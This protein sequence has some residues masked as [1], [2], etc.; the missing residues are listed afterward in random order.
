MS[1]HFAERFGINTFDK[2]RMKQKLP[3]PVYQKWKNATRKEDVLDRDTADMIA[4]AMKTWAIENGATHYCHWFQPLNGL[5]AKKHDAFLDQTEDHE[6]IAR[7]SGKE[8]IKGE[9]DASSFPSGGMRST[10][11]A[12]GYTYWDCTANTFIVD[13][14][15]YIPSIFVSFNGETLD[16]KGPL[17]KSM[18]YLS[19]H[20]NRVYNL[21]SDVHSYRCRVKVGLEQEFFLID[22]DL[23]HKRPDI[24]GCGR[25]LVGAAPA[26]V[27]LHDH[28]FGAF[29]DRVNAFYADVNEALWDLGIF[30][31]TEHNEAAPCQFELA[32]LFDNANISIDNNLMVMEVLKKCARKHGL[33]CLLHEKPFRYING[34]GKHNNWS[35]A[36]NFGENL[37]EP[38]PDPFANTRFLLYTSAVIAA[39]DE[40]AGLLRFAASG[41]SNDERL[42]AGEAPPAIISVY[43]GSTIEN[44]IRS[45][46]GKGSPEV[47]NQPQAFKIAHLQYA[48]H[49]DT[50]RNRTSP[51]AFTGN[52][53]E[54]RMLGSSFSAADVNIALSTAVG[55]ILKCIAD[56]LEKVDKD[57]REALAREI[58][59]ELISQ[60]DRV[61]FSG[62]GYSDAWVEEAAR[63]GLPHLRTYRESVEVLRE[64]KVQ[65]LFEEADIYSR[66]EINALY[67]I[68]IEEI[69]NYHTQEFGTMV[70]LMNSDIIPT[71]YTELVDL[72]RV[73][74]ISD[75]PAVKR[76]FEK[77][78]GQLES[79]INQ[80]DA[81]E[82]AYARA[83][84]MTGS[85]AADRFEALKGEMARLR[86]EVDDIEPHLSRKNRI[87]PTYEDIF[88][89][90]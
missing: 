88:N 28:Y 49:D 37:F 3:Y 86:A 71:I 53:F 62:D 82:Q 17:L 25:T 12:R 55:S 73:A 5:T 56:R 84:T 66:R 44:A 30:A 32:V 35:I 61:L 78:N 87:L 27:Q 41:P 14:I 76:R 26:K 43:L 18:D 72:G 69:I 89:A 23:Y 51:F 11:E 2:K 47:C 40:Y 58:C 79:L 1:K 67:N 70:R 57:A 39:V 68:A 7:F 65:S 52:K 6:P 31:K 63:R 54:F 24:M 33:V 16:K 19:D 38:G 74:K 75:N 60:H 45:V 85:E 83:R 10:F 22:E 81:F 42:G 4:H 80:T 48:P 34:S 29:P 64:N 13:N 46:L 9:P 20:A 50:D 90:I 15:M 36:T 21:M 77:L 8:L 59:A